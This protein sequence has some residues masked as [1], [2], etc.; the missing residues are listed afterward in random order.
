MIEVEVKFELL[1]K[2]WSQFKEHFAAMQFVRRVRNSDIYYDTPRFDLL[3]QAVF[4][5]VRN[6]QWLEF[7][8]NAQAAPTHIQ[9]TERSFALNLHPSQAEEMHA[10][11]AR[12]LP[13]WCAAAAPEEALHCNG[14]RELARIE[15]HRT[16][17]SYENLIICV[18]Q[19]E[20]L[21]NFV[22]IEM[23]CEEDSDIQQAIAR[24]QD[25][26]AG[27]AARQVRVGYVELWLQ[28]YHPQAYRLG[29]Y[30]E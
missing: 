3:R 18:D 19:V 25:L 9:S 24:V 2:A 23:Q 14:L 17:Y 12:F 8:F 13:R 11:F 5:R 30:Q 4:V 29:K 27:F 10:L 22:E 6:Q 1:P 7:K 28:R 20:G 21:G 15:N 16:Q 26:A